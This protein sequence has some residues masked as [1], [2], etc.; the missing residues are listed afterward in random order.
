MGKV[1]YAMNGKLLEDAAVLL[2]S[3]AMMHKAI[4]GTADI[5]ECDR[6]AKAQGVAGTQLMEAAGKAVSDAIRKRWAA[7]ST[8]ILCGPGNNGGD[9]YVVARHLAQQGWPVT[10]ASLVDPRQ[11]KGDALW[12]FRSWAGETGA[13]DAVNAGGFALIIDAMFG[14]GLTRGLSGAAAACVREA[15]AANAVR[16]AI[17]LPSGLAGDHEPLAGPVFQAD[18]SVTFHRVKPAHILQAGRDVCGEVVCA[19]IG[20]PEGWQ[21]QIRPLAFEN[22]PHVWQDL[23]PSTGA[24]THKHQKGRLA[25]FS[26]PAG[27]TGAARLAAMTGL[28]VGAG[29]VTVLS[30]ASAMAENAE[31][32]TAIMLREVINQ[33]L[34]ALADLRA[35][36]AVLGP[37]YG[38]GALT[39]DHVLNLLTGASLLVL[40]ADA[41]SSFE[42]HAADLFSAL[43]PDDVMTP[44]TGEFRRLFP[45]L[46]D[47]DRN[48]IEAVRSAAEKAGC[49]VL[50]KGPDTVIAAPGETPVVNIHAAPALATAGSGDVLA[51][52]IAGLLVQGM[53]SFDAACAAAWLHGDAGLRL[54]QGL[55]A[56]DLPDAIADSLVRLARARRQADAL[57]RLAK[58][59]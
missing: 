51:G 58:R 5:G 55:V 8:L 17:D 19:D 10:V 27:S 11:L 15:N 47:S 2:H 3:E 23:L 28:R 56:E 26:G 39:R 35:G 4:L 32:L 46:L 12:A 34:S 33:P 25:V 7:R 31:Q 52:V 53:G 20:I 14:A 30:P 21:E 41:L 37:A 43:R 57:T 13:A 54:G 24:N 49:V 40:D 18:L 29:L 44:H 50:L 16:V 42:H 38:T 1:C 22:S 48:K 9:G 36:G 6:F 59:S 45:N